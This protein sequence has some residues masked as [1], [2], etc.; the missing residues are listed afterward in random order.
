[1]LNEVKLEM[2][3]DGKDTVTKVVKAIRDTH[4]YEEVVCDVYA[5]CDF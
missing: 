5:L 3:V 2:S 1:M 4:P